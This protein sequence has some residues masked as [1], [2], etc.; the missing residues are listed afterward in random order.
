MSRTK[1]MASVCFCAGLIGALFNSFAAWLGGR[2]G[3]TALA[4][5]ALT[6]EWT[7]SWLYPRLIW[8]GLWGLAFFITVASPRS[9]NRWIRK[10]LWASLL[11]TAWQLFYVFPNQTPHGA[12]G[13]ALGNATPLF[14]I[15]YNLIWGIFTGFFARLLWG[16]S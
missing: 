14:V 16:R 4:G 7:L 2:I 9:R 15:G 10:G 6:P 5:V 3:L 11:P 8:G 12:L 13:L 1:A